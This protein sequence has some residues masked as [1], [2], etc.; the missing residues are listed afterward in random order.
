[1]GRQLAVCGSG[2]QLGEDV[3]GVL[4]LHDGAL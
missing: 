2:Q 3:R 1:M 4:N